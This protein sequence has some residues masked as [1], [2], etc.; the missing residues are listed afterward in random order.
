MTMR[1][2][3]LYRLTFPNGKIY[4][5]ITRE[6][7][8]RRVMRH[9]QYAREGRN[10]ALSCAIRKYGETSFSSEIIGGGNWDELKSL[11]IAEIKRL[12]AI[13]HGLYNMTDG[14]DGSLGVSLRVETKLK[15]SSSLRG[16]KCSDEHRRRVSEAQAGKTIPAEVREKMRQAA[17]SRVARSPMSE[18]QKQ[19]IRASLLGK[20]QTPEHIAKRVA[21]RRA[22]GS[23][24]PEISTGHLHSVCCWCCSN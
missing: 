5:G 17:K 8:K 11:E 7:L 13:G 9:I 19:K 12:R 1:T 21:A 23:Y 3:F 16:R 2:G 20:K 18:E 24:K 22:N 6:T 10:Y 15:I 14:G 4:I